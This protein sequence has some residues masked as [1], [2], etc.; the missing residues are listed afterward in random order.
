MSEYKKD[1]I[2]LIKEYLKI[3]LKVDYEKLET[4]V[5]VGIEHRLFYDIFDPIMKMTK[6][7]IYGDNNE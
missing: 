7:G 6:D 2:E 3:L 5:V 1:N 4:F